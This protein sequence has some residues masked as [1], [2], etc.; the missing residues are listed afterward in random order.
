MS[1]GV[2][3]LIF[4]VIFVVLFFIAAGL[5]PDGDSFE[6][7][8]PYTR[9]GWMSPK[10]WALGIC[11]TGKGNTYPDFRHDGGSYEGFTG[12]YTGTWLLDRRKGYPDHA[13]EATPRQQNR[14][15]HDSLKKGRYYG[16]LHNGGY[17]RWMS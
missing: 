2:R 5:A 1:T 7:K 15:L 12:W 10:A 11:E 13:Y 14:V 4:I 8:Q 3:N 16:C 17:R 9:P 6:G